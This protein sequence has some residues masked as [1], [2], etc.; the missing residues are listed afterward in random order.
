[1]RN[2]F[3]LVDTRELVATVRS[4]EFGRNELQRYLP[5]TEVVDI[6]FRLVRVDRLNR[7][8]PIRAFDTPAPRGRRPG[9]TELR[10]ALPPISEILDLTESERLRLRRLIGGGDVAELIADAIFNDAAITA[11]AVANRLELLR[12]EA[13]ATGMIL[14]DENG[15][16]Q[17]V[18]YEIPADNK[19]VAPVAWTGAADIVN[20]FFTWQEQYVDEAGS[21]AVEAVMSTRARSLA[22]RNAGVRDLV[23]TAAPQATPQALNDVLEANGLP[24]IRVYDRKVEDATGVV[25]RVIPEDRVIFLPGDDERVGETQLGVTE[26]AVALV[27]A[28]ELDL[29]DAP[30]LTA[31]VMQADEPVRTS[32]KV[33]GIGLPVIDRPE[34]VLTA[35]I[36][37]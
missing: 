24:R 22:L 25:Q 34:A 31:V 2:V 36:G 3:D 17:A 19:V 8:A 16:L 9:A 23:G 6:D 14:I 13:L 28:R 10:G 15:V 5:N 37:I 4:L 30:G 12:G 33:A 11:A 29:D 21:G 35:D 1:M 32:T 18:D 27:N 20:D 26:E 7:A